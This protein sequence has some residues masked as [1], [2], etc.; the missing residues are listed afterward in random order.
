VGPKVIAELKKLF[1]LQAADIKI[2]SLEQGLSEMPELLTQAREPRTVAKVRVEE[3]KKAL[4]EERVEQRRAESALNDAETQLAHLEANS[5]QV[6][7]NEAYTAML[8]EI[9]GAKEKISVSE[10]QIL[11]GMEAIEES[12]SGLEEAS[13]ISA[14]TDARVATEEEDL[15]KKEDELS[16][17]L[18]RQRELRIERK[19]LVDTELLRAYDRVAARKLPAMAAVTGKLCGSCHA[20]L[21][22]QLAVEARAAQSVVNCRGCKRILVPEDLLKQGEA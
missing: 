1:S 7:S 4:E 18:E 11:E 12:A 10:T 22:A 3:V 17:E 21:P 19:A 6:N 14:E 20:V 16:G 5:S 15:A 2:R 8:L 9:D 13:R